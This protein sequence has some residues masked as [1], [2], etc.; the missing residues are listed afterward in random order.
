MNQNS[1]DTA[2]SSSFFSSLSRFWRHHRPWISLSSIIIIRCLL[3]IHLNGPTPTPII[4]D[5]SWWR[6][7]E[8]ATPN[9]AKYIPRT[10]IPDD[11]RQWIIHREDRRLWRHPG[12]DPIALTRAI[13]HNLHNPHAIQGA[14]TLHAQIIKNHDRLTSNQKKRT[15]RTKIMEFARAP[16]LASWYTTTELLTMR[17]NTVPFGNGIIGFERASRQ[18]FSQSLSDIS[19]YQRFALFVM[20]RNPTVYHPFTNP[21]VFRSRYNR[22]LTACIRAA[23]CPDNS[24]SSQNWPYAF[25]GADVVSW[26]ITTL[27]FSPLSPPN[28]A[29]YITNTLTTRPS[30]RMTIQQKQDQSVHQNREKTHIRTTIDS[31]LS[32]AIFARMRQVVA[33]YH[34]RRVWDAA[35]IV[36]DHTTH[37]VKALLGGIDF[38]SETGWQVNAVFAR[39]QPWSALKPFVYLGAVLQGRSLDTTILD[40]RRSYQTQEGLPYE[41]HNIDL[42]ERWAMTL[43][44][45]LATSRNTPAVDIT[46]R[47]WLT[48]IDSLFRHVNLNLTQPKEHY[49]LA[50]SLG[51]PDIRLRDLVHSYGIFAHHGIRCSS[52]LIQGDVIQCTPKVSKDASRIID[53]ALRSRALRRASFPLYGTLDYPDGRVGLKTGTSRNFS[54]NW[55]ILWTDRYLIGIWVGNKDWSPMHEVTWSMGAWEI[56]QHIIALLEPEI[57]AQRLSIEPLPTFTRTPWFAK[58]MVS[59]REIA[60]PLAWAYKILPWQTDISLP[61]HAFVPDA[62]DF[63]W[64]IHT[65]QG[66]K[67][68]WSWTHSIRL[69]AWAIT[70]ILRDASG[71]QRASRSLTIIPAP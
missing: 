59:D 65:S 10:T 28:R 68:Y 52:A 12:I 54:D 25:T 71:Q 9:Q 55:L 18:F 22:M 14:S 30:Q 43:A 7:G 19:P 46:N 53:T 58:P 2:M 60:T 38:W 57:E 6:L 24:Q 21:D 48:T 29:G 35:V 3:P 4:L 41:P 49:G 1:Y 31:P 50:L 40:I 5:S 37:E 69:Q 11:L 20:A 33:S 36:I 62:N 61:L 16:R 23:L 13:W 32:D 66:N 26:L 8:Q 27:T 70:I 42:E 67:E 56:G 63:S 15:I 44:H 51:A 47:I 17:T 45:A 34:H 64:E 39:N